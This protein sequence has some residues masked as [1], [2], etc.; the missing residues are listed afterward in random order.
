M[1]TDSTFESLISAAGLE[2]RFG[3]ITAVN[4]IQF[5]VKRGELVG[6]LGPNGA[7]KSTTLRMLAGF[8]DPD[9]G[10]VHIAGHSMT[11]QRRAAQAS[12]GY[13]PE[14]AP[15]YEALTARELFAFVGRARGLNRQ[16]FAERLDVVA[17]LARLDGRLDQRFENLSK[18]FRRRVAIA[19]GLLADPDVLILDEPTDGLDP[20]Q[21]RG[22]R[23]DLRALAKTKAILISTHILEEVPALCDRVIVIDAG[24]VVFT[25]TPAEFAASGDG[26]LDAAFQKVTEVAR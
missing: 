11:S 1:T 2:K 10:S 15:G 24:R 4:A 12:L 19:A 8:L 3:S 18:G 16:R 20:N 26:N 25:G 7:G 6:L 9:K 13:V 21:K 17:Q 5:D 22:L 14:G 23:R